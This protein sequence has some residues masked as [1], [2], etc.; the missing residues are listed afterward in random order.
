MF[1]WVG[2]LVQLKL[3]RNETELISTTLLVKIAP[4][5]FSDGESETSAAKSDRDTASKLSSASRDKGDH[6]AGGCRISSFQSAQYFS[7]IRSQNLFRLGNFS[8][9]ETANRGSAILC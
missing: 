7:F 4:R 2:L 5:K 3:T 8:V 1:R 9:I 6:S